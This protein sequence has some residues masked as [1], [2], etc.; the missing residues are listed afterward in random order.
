MKKITASLLA[1]A[2]LSTVTTSA[3]ASDYSD[4][5]RDIKIS[6]SAL[7]SQ[8]Q[9]MNVEYHTVEIESGLNRSQ[10]VRALEAKYS[11]LQDQFNNAQH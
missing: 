5:V 2:A 8:L 3:F 6:V 10:E 11:S 9:S 7:E 1:I 4:E